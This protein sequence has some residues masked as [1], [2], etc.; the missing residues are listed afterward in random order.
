MHLAARSSASSG[1]VPATILAIATAIVVVG[2]GVSIGQ[3]ATFGVYVAFGIALPGLLWVRFLRGR[4]GYIAE[5]VALGLCAGYA[6]EIATY[7]VARALG[8]PLLF[9]AWPIATL[10][11]FTAVPGLR[12]HWRGSGIRAP[13]AWS[14]SLAAILGILLA[15]T[16]GIFFARH[17]LTGTDTPYVDM[18]YH[19]A[20]IGELRHHVPPAIPYVIDVPLAYHWFFYAEAAATSWATGIEPIVLLYRLSGLPMFAA[21]VVLTAMAAR[22][23]TDRWWTGPLAVV[24]ALFAV[25]AG[26][27]GW[28]VT[29]VLDSQPLYVAWISPTTLFGLALFAALVLLFI[30]VLGPIDG[31]DRGPRTAA[32]T[33]PS[34][35]ARRARAGADPASPWRSGRR[36]RVCP[37]PGRRSACRVPPTA[38]ATWRPPCRAEARARA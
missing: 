21:F 11:A 38:P 15:Y 27:Y 24:V 31:P 4:A 13:A 37:S 3:V 5:D 29:P 20:L 10:V 25:V 36:T 16:A 18:A 34:R 22:R 12:S 17:H 26:P 1:W 30:D 8:A 33:R 7:L 14:W 19:L 35:S 9:L 32:G 23:L 6:I 2:Y 28:A